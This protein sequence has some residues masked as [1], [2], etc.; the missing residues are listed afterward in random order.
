MLEL[1]DLSVETLQNIPLNPTIREAYDYLFAN[2]PSV[3]LP[4]GEVSKEALTRYRQ[5]HGEIYR[6]EATTWIEEEPQVTIIQSGMFGGKTTL[7]FNLEDRLKEKGL[8]VTNLI[9]YV[10][11][12]DYVTGRSYSADPKKNK[13]PAIKFGDPTTYTEEISQLMS[14]D[15]DYLVLD[16][17]S[18][19]PDMQV[20]QALILACIKNGKGIVLT[21]LDTN[22]LGYPLPPF[23]ENGFVKD[24]TTAKKL[25]CK[26]FVPGICED[27]PLG[28]NTIRY[29][30]IDGKWILDI[31][32]Y[33][34]VVSKEHNQ[35]V[36]YA[37]AMKSQTASH[38]F[39]DDPYLLSAILY[40]TEL[41]DI[42]RRIFLKKSLSRY[43]EKE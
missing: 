22:Y 9:A 31:G 42:Q 19:L 21:G 38:I 32:I 10:M 6:E 28:T 1:E 25:Y 23:Q 40:P 34:T 2:D 35:V 27:I 33:P 14:G 15:S 39:R 20:V 7:A 30:Y 37:P 5:K 29:A 3:L 8:H 24:L 41:E 4:P 18:F 16:E 36:R 12:E 17:F 26:S 11:G 13:R 43:N